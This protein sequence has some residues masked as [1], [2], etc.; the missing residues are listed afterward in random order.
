MA[1]KAT[2]K[3]SEVKTT[4]AVRNTAIPKAVPAP[5]KLEVTFER[6]QVRAYEIYC[7]GQGGGELDHWLQAERELRV[8]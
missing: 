1:R 7:S 6:I 8:A 5:A 3:K 4:T 2:T